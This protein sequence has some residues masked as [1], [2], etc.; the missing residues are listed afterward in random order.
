MNVAI[1]EVF[2]GAEACAWFALRVDARRPSVTSAP[3]SLVRKS[4]RP[5]VRVA[6]VSGS[7]DARFP[8]RAEFLVQDILLRRGIEAWVPV[9]AVWNRANRYRRWQKVVVYQPLLPGY[10]LAA[11]PLTARGEDGPAVDWAGVLSCPMVRG[12]IAFGGAPAAI[13]DRD[14]QR[15]RETE[16]GEQADLLERLMPT[17]RTFKAGQDVEILDGPF[18]EFRAQVIEIHP[19]EAVVLC[20]VFGRDTPLRVDLGS[21]GSI[22]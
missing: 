15:L 22:S 20:H 18:R 8:A 11:L 2:A 7:K 21:L 14:I 4:P 17:G 9:R 16:A 1:T 5:P 13:R 6:G 10:V 12:V 19:T 3:L